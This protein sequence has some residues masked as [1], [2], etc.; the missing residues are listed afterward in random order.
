MVL[1]WWSLS[2]RSLPTTRKSQL[3]LQAPSSK[4]NLSPRMN[5]DFQSRSSA[6]HPPLLEVVF[7]ELSPPNSSTYGREGVM[8]AEVL[9]SKSL[10]IRADP[11]R[12]VF[13]FAFVLLR[14]FLPIAR[15]E[16]KIGA[17]VWKQVF[18][19]RLGGG[20]SFERGQ[21]RLR[22]AFHGDKQDACKV[23]DAISDSGINL[24]APHLV[25]GVPQKLDHVSGRL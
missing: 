12:K 18:D 2:S 4:E 8:K 21:A 6:P 17:F 25:D 14:R 24:A 13:A 9:F 5:T 11:W 15:D 16:D 22:G 10:L 7:F 23:S 19:R 20:H 3:K 1:E